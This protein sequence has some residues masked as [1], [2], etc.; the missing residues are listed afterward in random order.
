[1][2]FFVY[3]SNMERA[4]L[5]NLPKLE[6]IRL[7]I[8]QDQVVRDQG[9]IIEDQAS[10]VERQAELIK[11]QDQV[12]Q[13]QSELLKAQGEVIAS[14]DQII[15]GNEQQMAAYKE[16]IAQLQRMLFGRKSERFEVETQQPPLPFEPGEEVV[17]KQEEQLTQRISY[18]RAKQSAHPGRLPLPAH[19]PVEE[20]EIHPQGDLAGMVCI[21]KEIT[22][23]LDCVPARFFIRRYIR[24]KY[25]PKGQDQQAGIL[26]A[27]LPERVIEKGIAGAGLLASILVDK[28]VDHLPLYR[29]VQR[30]ARNKIPIAASTLEGWVKQGLD[31]LEPL[32][33]HLV[34]D[35]KTQGY[36]QVD[37]TPIRVLDSDK[38]GASHRGFYW[39]YHNPINK[40]VLFDYHPSRGMEGP[41]R[42]LTGFKG[43]LQTD[44]YGVYSRLASQ[45]EV[46]HLAC[47]AHA[48]REFERAQENDPTRSAIALGLIQQL[49]GIEAQAREG[50]LSPDQRKELRLEKSFPILNELGKWISQE[51]K[52]SLPKSQLG[53]A[54]HYTI[55]RWGA[56]HA[57][58][59]D[60]LLEIDN[61][62]VE[63]AIRPVALG[64]K[65]YL[66]A[67]SHAA[68]Q[69]AAMLYSFL[70]I[71]KKHEVDPFAWLKYTLEHTM[72]IP[73][74][75]IRNLYPQ[76][77]KTNM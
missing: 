21:G 76:N 16:L 33:E 17:A 52:Y 48:R 61:N 32:Y 64:R 42:M 37:E 3:V 59:Q 19:L 62:L 58:L 7:L 54:L 69:R 56:L 15:E 26:M 2:V 6:L 51:F 72:I 28:Y 5:N 68:A 41:G 27:D 4:A 25:A 12:L 36:L 35:T 74:K 55:Q 65:N 43:Y 66:F 63:N 45:L 1:V 46:T 73:Y 70:A 20:V 47:W 71:C 9:K 13:D 75:E 11:D 50:G 34:E 77:F 31:R 40:T 23:E 22:E 44:G 60:G 67:G 53:K 8:K 10:L 14:K 49:Y 24:Y 38:P 18:L 39:V 57:Y 30:F 29:Q